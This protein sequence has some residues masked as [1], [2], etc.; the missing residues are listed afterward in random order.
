ML[1]LLLRHSLKYMY[2]TSKPLV[3][4]LSKCPKKAKGNT[5]SFTKTLQTLLATQTPSPSPPGRVHQDH[6]P[7]FRVTAPQTPGAP[8]LSPASIANV[9]L[10]MQKN[11]WDGFGKG[12]PDQVSREAAPL[13][14]PCPPIDCC[15]HPHPERVL[16]ASLG[17]EPPG[18]V[19]EAA[20]CP[21]QGIP[22]LGTPLAPRS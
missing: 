7:C 3:P 18:L 6:L 17:E 16:G 19:T 10:L 20:F 13:L 14:L 15:P 9:P 12:I 8:T 4:H 22:E 2:F 1:P 5:K 11:L 21:V